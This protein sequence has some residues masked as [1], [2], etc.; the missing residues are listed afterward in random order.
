[1]NQGQAVTGHFDPATVGIMPDDPERSVLR[2]HLLRHGEVE[3]FRERTLRGQRDVPLSTLGRA[4]HARLAA[5]MARHEPRPDVVISSDLGRCLDLGERL[6]RATGAELRTEPCLREQSFG[7]WEGRSWQELTRA[8]GP[9]VTAWWDDYVDARPPGGESL[10]DLDARVAAWWESVAATRAGGRVAVVTHIGVVRVMLCRALGLPLDQAL[11]WAP[12]AASHT[13]LDLAPTGAVLGTLGERPWLMTHVRGGAAEGHAALS[14][15]GG[16]LRLAL[17]GSAGTGK[18]TLGRRL[19]ERLG[20]PFLEEGMRER[21]ARG[22]DL[23]ALLKEGQPGGLGALMHELWEEQVAR[24]D[25]CPTGFVADRSAADY[26]AFWM[27][28]ELHHD[29]AAS[30]AWMQAM[31]V[32]LGRYDRIVVCPWGVL[33]LADDGVRSTNRWTQLRFQGLLQGWLDEFAPAGQVLHVPASDDAPTRLD[34]VLQH[35][36]V[37]AGAG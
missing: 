34:T 26:A 6:A 21:L 35:L 19:A 16:R 20:L 36:G 13:R 7:D 27:H 9:A 37:D 33:P 15:A 12:P 29:H 4:Q 31:S 3:R 32:A 1:M 8:D 11:R 10:A 24:E 14:A 17:S 5:W 23:H 28:Y 2:L 30:E 22:L 25:A 18:T